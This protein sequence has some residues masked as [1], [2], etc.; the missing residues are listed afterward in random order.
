MADAFERQSAVTFRELRKP[1]IWGAVAGG[2][3]FAFI[4]YCVDTFFM[5]GTGGAGLGVV[6]GVAFGGLAGLFYGLLR[7]HHGHR[8]GA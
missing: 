6:S 2:L 4:A 3:L 1:A 5:P 7:S 8:H